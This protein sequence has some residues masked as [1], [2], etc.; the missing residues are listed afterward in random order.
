MEM[1]EGRIIRRK[2]GDLRGDRTD[3]ARV[4]AMTEEEIN[5]AA[6]SDPDNPP[7]D[8]EFWKNAVLTMPHP[9]QSISLRVDQDVLEW[10]KSRG[11]GYQTLMN[12]VLRSYMEAQKK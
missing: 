12:A 1:K 6:M 9:K 8:Y 5:E 10:F 2:L 3:W 11:R 7:T 4:D